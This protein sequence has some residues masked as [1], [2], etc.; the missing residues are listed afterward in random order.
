[1]ILR[2]CTY[3]LKIDRNNCFR[4]YWWSKNCKLHVSV[5]NNA[6]NMNATERIKAPRTILKIDTKKFINTPF[7]D[8]LFFHLN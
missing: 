2:Q 3:M 4:L 5:G 1:M 7:V 6:A 8:Y